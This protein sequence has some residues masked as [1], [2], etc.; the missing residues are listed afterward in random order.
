[1][2]MYEP[3]TVCGGQRTTFR[4]RFSSSTIRKSNSDYLPWWHWASPWASFHLYVSV[5]SCGTGRIHSHWDNS[6]RI[7]SSTS[8]SGYFYKAPSFLLNC[9]NYVAKAIMH[10][11]ILAFSAQL[12]P[13]WPGKMFIHQLSFFNWLLPGYPS[14]DQLQ[15]KRGNFQSPSQ[16]TS[17]EN[18]EKGPYYA[19]GAWILLRAHPF[20]PLCCCPS[21]CDINTLLITFLLQRITSP[22]CPLRTPKSNLSGLFPPTRLFFCG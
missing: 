22:P 2:W 19:T 11:W 9:N 14:T 20:L 6:P 4:N 8:W 3:H 18:R 7:S 5:F 21:V 15:T 12:T 10:L 1:M 17:C 13:Q 16:I